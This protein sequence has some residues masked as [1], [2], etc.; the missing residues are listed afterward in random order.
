NHGLNSQTG[1]GEGQNVADSAGGARWTT[2]PNCGGKMWTDATGP[3][4]DN[5]WRW[6]DGTS[7]PPADPPA[8]FVEASPTS[9][10]DSF[11]R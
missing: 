5:I 6:G 2:T 11:L 7:V 8:T 3:V 10:G 4:G 1:Y 9:S